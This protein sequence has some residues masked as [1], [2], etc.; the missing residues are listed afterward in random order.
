LIAQS[1]LLKQTQVELFELKEDV[2]LNQLALNRHFAE[3]EQSAV[4]KRV[5]S[6][7]QSLPYGRTTAADKR[8]VPPLKYAGSANKQ[9]RTPLTPLQ[10]SWDCDYADYNPSDFTDPIAL[11]AP[12][13]DGN[14]VQGL[15]FNLFDD[16]GVD[17]S[18][19]TADKIKLEPTTGRPVNPYGRTGLRGR[20]VL[21]RWGA[22]HAIDTLLAR[23]RRMPNGRIL[24][25]GGKPVLEFVAVQDQAGEGMVFEL[26][27][28]LDTDGQNH[29]LVH[30]SSLSKH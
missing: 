22:N 6:T 30:A 17:R 9:P 4:D 8:W 13:A 10:V 3:Q 19:K 23:W 14:D 15:K 7:N 1:E 12:E 16:N 29:S 26:L 5:S 24:Q 25:R 2:V 28:M 11:Q 27:L 18:S 20:G 21:K